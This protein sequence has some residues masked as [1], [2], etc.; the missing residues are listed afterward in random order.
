M[1]RYDD[2]GFILSSREALAASELLPAVPCWTTDDAFRFDAELADAETI[3]V[4]LWETINGDYMLLEEDILVRLAPSCLADNLG[5]PQDDPYLDRSR[6][7]R[8]STKQKLELVARSLDRIAQLTS[9]AK[10]RISLGANTRGSKGKEKKRRRAYNGTV[11]RYCEQRGT[12]KFV[13]LDDVVPRS[14]ILNSQHFTRKGYFSL[15]S[16][17]TREMDQQAQEKAEAITT[18]FAGAGFSDVLAAG[19][20]LRFVD[21]KLRSPPSQWISALQ[22]Y[23]SELSTYIEVSIPFVSTL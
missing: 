3:I 12:F 21:G 19:L 6:F 23:L 20:P 16:A 2:P 10:I 8:L 14:E 22:L 9:R 18:A 4:S 11:A 1:V 5:R 17:V 7:V 15:A 13:S